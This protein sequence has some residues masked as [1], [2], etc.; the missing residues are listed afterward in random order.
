M[1]NSINEI[2]DASCILAIGSN[3]VSA[4]PVIGLEIVRAVR[5]GAKLIVA[6][7]KEIDLTQ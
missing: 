4:H 6:N 7:P 1:T 3:T 5:K 2:G